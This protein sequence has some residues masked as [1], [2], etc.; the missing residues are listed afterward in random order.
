MLSAPAGAP[1]APRNSPVDSVDSK[2]QHPSLVHHSAAGLSRCSDRLI[3]YSSLRYVRSPHRSRTSEW[4]TR[5]VQEMHRRFSALAYPEK[6]L[7]VSQLVKLCRRSTRASRRADDAGESVHGGDA[8]SGRQIAQTQ[9]SC[10]PRTKRGRLPLHNLSRSA[11]V[12]ALAGTRSRSHIGSPSAGLEP[13][14]RR[15]SPPHSTGIH[16]HSRAMQNPCAP[17]STRRSGSPARPICPRGCPM[18]CRYPLRQAFAWSESARPAGVRCR[19]HR[20]ASA[21]GLRSP[22]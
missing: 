5:S 22:S 20:Q 2:R 13:A 16:R 21:T 11:W 10:P 4:S 7:E 3:K 6:I 1:F 8:S 15:S 14:Q 19:R 12:H 17:E 9:R 18:R